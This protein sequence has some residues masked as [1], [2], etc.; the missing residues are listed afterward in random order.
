LY[1]L[2]TC[3]ELAAPHWRE[4]EKIA[5]IYMT[6]LFPLLAN[7]D[8]TKYIGVGTTRAAL[9]SEGGKSDWGSYVGLGVEY[10]KPYSIL[11]AVEANY[12][13]KK[14]TLQNKSW[15]SESYMIESGKSIGDIPIDGS[16]LELAAKIG[17]R[18]SFAN[19]HM[20]IKVFVG[21]AISN[22]LKYLRRVREKTHLWYDPEKGPYT[23]DYLPFIYSERGPYFFIYDS[24]IGA[25]FSYKD[26]GVE[27]HYARSLTELEGIHSFNINDKLD[28]IYIV[29]RYSF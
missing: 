5:V 17:C 20:S 1:V 19:N 13:T 2:K 28:S 27:F 21:S 26:F 15:P 29:A 12:A 9:R 16:Y 7:A 11:L 4:Y 3:D 14:V 8:I 10:S 25:V 22:Q 6:I 18:I 24:I 23:F